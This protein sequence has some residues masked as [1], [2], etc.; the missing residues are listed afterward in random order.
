[1]DCEIRTR[2]SWPWS[3]RGAVSS[4]IAGT[5]QGAYVEEGT[6]EG[7]LER[8]GTRISAL[9]QGP[10]P[11]SKCHISFSSPDNSLVRLLP[12]ASSGRYSRLPHMPAVRTTDTYPLLYTYL[13]QLWNQELG[14]ALCPPASL[15]WAP[16]PAPM[17]SDSSPLSTRGSEG[18]GT[19]ACTASL[20]SN[21]GAYERF[22]THLRLW[23][24]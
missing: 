22:G 16:M 17:L 9:Q 7:S 21:G 4:T 10:A 23:R 3:G 6:L 18:V 11:A 14:C 5:T 19:C 13:P 12:F 15:L 1:M 8:A 2:P 20:R 24:S